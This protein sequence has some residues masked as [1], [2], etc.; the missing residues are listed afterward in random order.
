MAKKRRG[1]GIGIF[2]QG[3]SWR[4]RYRQQVMVKGVLDTV[5]RSAKICPIGTSKS[6]RPPKYVEDIAAEILLER[7]SRKAS[8][9]TTTTIGDFVDN[10]YIPSVERDKK[11]ST[12]S[13]YKGIWERYLRSRCE[14]VW[15]RDVQTFHVQRWLDD[16]ARESGVS[17]TTLSHTKHFLSGVF[18][19]A[20]QQGFRNAGN[21]VTLASIPL[22]APKAEEREAYTLEEIGAMLKILPEPA[23]T[24][25]ETA[26]WTGLRASELRGLTWDCL[27][28]PPDNESMAFLEVRR[29]IWRN[30]IGDPKTERSK[31]PVPVVP[32]LAARLMAHRRACGNPSSGPIFVNGRGNPMSL[33]FLY[34]QKMKTVLKKAGIP[35][36][37][38]HGFRRGLASNLNRLGVDDSVIQ[39]ILRHSNVAVTQRC[40]I[41]T[42]SQDAV[43]AMQ[44][45]SSRM[46]EIKSAAHLMDVDPDQV[47][48]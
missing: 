3:G 29:A 39:A 16:I 19:Y 1:R 46:A 7:K 5:Q 30:H 34:W 6:K 12:A 2:Q 17:R 33:D 37:G 21:P 18:R 9:D 8:P 14:R 27:T 23:A 10:S 48:Q 35:W 36:K 42:T 45:L 43:L 24:V 4:V 22:S 11:A 44:R 26:A 32:Q 15:L 31:A 47:V 20:A 40:Y 41:K 13:G 28:L 25:V 38:W